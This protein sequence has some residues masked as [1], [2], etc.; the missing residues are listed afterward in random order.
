MDSI[1]GYCWLHTEF[2]INHPLPFGVVGM[3]NDAWALICL[4]AHQCILLKRLKMLYFIVFIE[5]QSL[6]N[7]AL[8]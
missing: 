7:G 5:G 1:G 6:P 3:V 4:L 8:P 2:I